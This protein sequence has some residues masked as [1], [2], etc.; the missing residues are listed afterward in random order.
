MST[1]PSAWPPVVGIVTRTQD[2]S[3]LLRRA[4]R[5][6]RAQSHPHWKLVV[7]NDGG[8]PAAVDALIAEQADPRIQVVHHPRALGMGATVNAGLRQLDSDL[9]AIHD[10][11]D[12]WAPEFLAV[13]VAEL[14]RLER[15]LPSVHGVATYC[16]RVLDRVSGQFVEVDQIE[17]FNLWAPPGLVSFHQLFQENFV[18][19]ISFVFRRDSAEALGGFRENLPDLADWDFLVRF[20]QRHDVYLIPEVLA[21]YH[22]RMSVTGTMEGAAIEDSHQHQLCR[23]VLLNEWLRRDLAGEGGGLGIYA[24][25]RSPLDLLSQRAA[26]VEKKLTETNQRLEDVQKTLYGKLI[27]DSREPVQRLQDIQAALYEQLLPRL[28]QV[29]SQSDRLKDIQTQLY[30]QITPALNRT[31]SQVERLV[32]LVQRVRDRFSSPLI[33]RI[34][35]R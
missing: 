9:V 33:N 21:F 3:P 13:C 8:D 4:L 18:P 10:D 1:S 5:S 35:R 20:L 17:P 12:S 14:S 28:N 24:S 25:L 23:T 32:G 27:P 19:P 31:L 22:H 16:N 26:A 29:L 34:L 30:E 2:R 6:V 7:V 11:A 15:T